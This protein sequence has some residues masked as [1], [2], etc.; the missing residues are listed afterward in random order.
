MKHLFSQSGALFGLDA[1]IALAVFALISVV[2][3]AAMVLNLDNTNAQSLASE[4]TDTTRA[5][6]TFHNDLQTDIFQ[7][8]T[9]PTDKNAFASLYDNTLISEDGQLRARWNGP[10]IKFTSTQH[11]K[12]GEMLLQKRSE[13]HTEAC[14]GDNLCFLYLVYGNTKEAVAMEVNKILDG[15]KEETPA[16]RGRIQWGRGDKA[17]TMHLYYRASKALTPFTEVQ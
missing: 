16:T 15:E 5:I 10:Y 13:A 4:L 9:D 7:A 14:T 11:P 3:G 1:R 17:T 12:Y 2:A 8:L 6:E